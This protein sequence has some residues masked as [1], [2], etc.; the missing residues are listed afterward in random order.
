M[1]EFNE[2]CMAMTGYSENQPEELEEQAR[3]E[4]ISDY[5]R[6]FLGGHSYRSRR[7]GHEDRERREDRMLPIVEV[8]KYGRRS[9]SR[10]S[11]GRFK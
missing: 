4:A 1:K 5:A 3:E 6:M 8:E 7:L 11:M 9:R 2:L 10:D